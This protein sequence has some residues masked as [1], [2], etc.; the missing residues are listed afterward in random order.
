MTG[1]LDG[2]GPPSTLFARNQQI[3]DYC[4]A[5]DK[6]LY[7]FADIESYDPDGNYYPW[8]SDACEWCSVWC[9]THPCCTGY[10]AHSHCFN[11]YQKGKAWW[12]MMATIE[13]WSF[14]LGVGEDE[15]ETLPESYYLHQGYPNPFNSATVISYDLPRAAE[16]RLAVYNVLGQEVRV[17]VNGPQPAGRHRQEWHGDGESGQAVASGCYLYRLEADD[18]V[19]TRKMLL[20]K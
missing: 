12:W 8:D 17:L 14:A 5:N 13:G 20:L 15:T 2:L 9:A 4:L 6:V 7:D 10:C 16:V 19:Q 18:F 3:R 11:C 1:H